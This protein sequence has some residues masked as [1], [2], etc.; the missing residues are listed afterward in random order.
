M[1]RGRGAH[2]AAATRRRA[3]P[4]PL[5]PTHAPHNTPK[6]KQTFNGGCLGPNDFVSDT[7]AEYIPGEDPEGFTCDPARNTC[8]GLINQGLDPIR[9]WM[10][11]TTDACL[12][13]F[14]AGQGRRM[15]EYWSVYRAGGK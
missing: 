1:G 5:H 6:T 9:N 15:H 7:P 14:S 8:P 13:S 11:Y 4:C 10:T 2:N 12:A 3:S